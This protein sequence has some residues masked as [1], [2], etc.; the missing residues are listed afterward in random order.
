[1]MEICEVRDECPVDTYP[2]VT[3][4]CVNKNLDET[5]RDIYEQDIETNR[6]AMKMITEEC[7]YGHDDD[8]KKN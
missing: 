1:M 3:E 4:Y 5:N 6:D 7:P 2:V 8:K